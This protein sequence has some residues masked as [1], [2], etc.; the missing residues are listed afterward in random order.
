MEEIV[1]P[2]PQV[3]DLLLELERAT[4]AGDLLTRA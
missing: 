3:N 1:I 2:W 4:D